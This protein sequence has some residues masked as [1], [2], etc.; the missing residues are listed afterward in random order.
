MS[1]TL[2]F[3]AVLLLST[4]TLLCVAPS[5]SRALT[6]KFVIHHFTAIIFHGSHISQPARSNVFLFRNQSQFILLL[7]FLSHWGPETPTWSV[8]IALSGAGFAWVAS[9]RVG[10]KTKL[11]SWVPFFCAKFS[12][13]IDIIWIISVCPTDKPAVKCSAEPCRVNTCPRHANARCENDYCGGCSA[14]FFEGNREVTNDCQQTQP[15]PPSDTAECPTIVCA[16]GVSRVFCLISPCMNRSC[17]RK[18]GALCCSSYCGNCKFDFY[19]NGYNVT[20][21]C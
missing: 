1:E 12:N 4:S 5:G 3:S 14:R 10:L 13:I 19:L 17:V 2:L 7:P 6:R 9:A 11:K 15:I 20:H 18:P 21:Q 8:S 16:P